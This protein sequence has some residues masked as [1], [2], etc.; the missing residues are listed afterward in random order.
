ML[1]AKT[2]ATQI[3]VALM[4]LLLLN[5]CASPSSSPAAD[6]SAAGDP[7]EISAPE[8][9]SPDDMFSSRDLEIGYDEEHSAV[10]TLSGTTASC[11]SDAVGI[12]GPSVIITDEGTYILSGTLEDGTVIV[13]AGKDDKV[14]IVLDG[15]S[16][17][18]AQGAA[19][20]V[21]SADKV[22]VT[23][24]S[25]SEN[26]LQNGGSYVQTDEN[27]VDAVVFSKADLTFNGSGTLTLRAD[28]GHGA[29]SK[30]D[31]VFT[32]G[33]YEVTAESH[34]LS[35]KDSV[36]ICGGTFTLHSGKD[37]VQAEHD[38]DPEKGFLYIRGGTFDI[39]SGGDGLSASGTVQIDGGEYRIQAGGGSKTAP[40]AA[41]STKG[42][43]S[44]AAMTL[45]GGSFTLDTSDDALHSNSDLTVTGG[46]YRISTGDD[47]LHADNA[48]S[49]AAGD[50]EIAESYEGLE[51]LT[52]DLSGGDISLHASDDGLNAAGGNDSSGTGR[53]GDPFAATEGAYIRIAGGTLTVS[54]EGDGIDSN[55]D[56]LISGGTVCVSGPTSNR[57]G[58]L[59][60]NGEA[61]I[62]GGVFLG[63]GSSGMAQTFGSASTQGAILVTALGIQEAGSTVTLTDGDGNTVVSWEPEKEYSSVIISTPDI[64]ADASYTLSAGSAAQDIA[65]D[66]LIYGAS[67]FSPG[68][69]GGM[70]GH[71]GMGG[72]H[73]FD[74]ERDGNPPKPPEGFS[75]P[76]E[77]SRQP[78][79]GAPQPPDEVPS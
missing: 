71:G 26:T 32:S 72:G 54:A 48:L 44:A 65:M 59:D 76:P 58:I 39:V 62:T 19:L 24:A 33:T 27:T 49:V 75:E 16:V 70:G 37:G 47:G 7:P 11:P 79:D 18:N 29:V 6:S 61:S 68:H 31:L 63:S 41:V 5:G 55:G 78:P 46:T 8:T 12:S 69:G 67:G 1:Q 9:L 66:G 52:I 50:I 3:C 28:A 4:L 43:K 38:E 36:R 14:Q 60:Y 25:Q 13:D 56:L 17:T 64:K 34:A 73:R 20:Y 57:D 40:D 51:G 23:T 15:A 53:L 21:R 10:I 22:F 2:R 35:G 42:I 45:A 74:G 30:D 77:G